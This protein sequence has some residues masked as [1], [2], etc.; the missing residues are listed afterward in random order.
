MLLRVLSIGG[1]KKNNVSNSRTAA[2]SPSNKSR[3][4]AHSAAHRLQSRYHIL[5]NRTAKVQRGVYTNGRSDP[6]TLP[7][8]TNVQY[9]PPEQSSRPRAQYDLPPGYLISQGRSQNAASG[10]RESQEIEPL[11][12][13]AFR[14]RQHA[15]ISLSCVQNTSGNR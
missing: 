11:E 15:T 10:S 2:D 7:A 6:R 14:Y 8:N 13:G 4:F 3:L 12:A 5:T 9:I 1:P